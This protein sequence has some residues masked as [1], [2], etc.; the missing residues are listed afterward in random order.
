[1]KNVQLTII[2]LLCI[3]ANYAKGPF[4]YDI[5]NKYRPISINTTDTA[6]PSIEPANFTFINMEESEA[7]KFSPNPT[8][9]T[10][11]ISLDVS[12]KVNATCKDRNR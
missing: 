1:M 10:F 12:G 3:K 11:A 6:L 4:T 2:M 5:D 7:I 8:N 9:G